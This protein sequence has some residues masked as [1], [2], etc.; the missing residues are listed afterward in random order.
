MLFKERRHLD[1]PPTTPQQHH[2][3]GVQSCSR[4][5]SVDGVCRQHAPYLTVQLVYYSRR[6]QGL[7]GEKGAR[8]GRAAGE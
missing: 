8:G 3:S 6:V 4:A 7:R 5:G 2:V 1:P